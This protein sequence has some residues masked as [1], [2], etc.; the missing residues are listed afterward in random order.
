MRPLGVTA[1][2]VRLRVRLLKLSDPERRPELRQ[3]VQSGVITNN[4]ADIFVIECRRS[5]LKKYE[6]LKVGEIAQ[7]EN[8]HPVDA[9]LD[10]AVADGLNTGFYTPLLNT[11]VDHV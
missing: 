2:P 5:E 7:M 10:I 4:V 9:M 11:R 8:K 1:Q 3:V 6:N